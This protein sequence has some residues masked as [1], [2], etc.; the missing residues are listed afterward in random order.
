[1]DASAIRLARA[2]APRGY[3]RGINVDIEINCARCLLN[4]NLLLAES[5]S[6]CVPAGVC[7]FTSVWVDE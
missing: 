7:A 6:C 1:M 3:P 2:L 5:E 4:W